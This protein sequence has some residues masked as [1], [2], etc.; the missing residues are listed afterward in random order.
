MQS[1]K[2]FIKGK[3]S[4]IDVQ[5]FS[6]NLLDNVVELHHDL[7]NKTYQHGPYHEFRINDP[8]PRNIHKP[9]VRDRLLHHAIYRQL[10]PIF[11]PTFITDS[12]SC[13]K[14]K[15]T[16]KA[17]NRFRGFGWQVNKND[18][19]TCWVLQCDIR[20]FFASI[21]QATLLAICVRKIT[22]PDTLWLLQE[23]VSSFNTT[24]PGIGLPLGNLTSQL[25]VNIYLNEFDQFA[26]HILKAKRYIRYADDFVFLSDDKSE[27]ES[28]LP[29]VKSFLSG[30]LNLALHPNKVH[31]RTLASGVDFLG[32]VH[33]PDHRVLRTK[34]KRRLKS[35]LADNPSPETIASYLG[36]L[37]H[38]NTYGLIQSIG[39]LRPTSTSG[40]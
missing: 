21:D 32:W 34:T 29:T 18:T 1:W 40:E 16:H 24:K 23:I 36:L 33:F 28:W 4:R 26:K 25:L 12:Y 13:R 3:R 20:Q 30:R 11:D 37:K 2:E 14:D 10:Y 6:E 9:T 17:L 8:K 38:G 7:I 19:R 5:I 15:G 27:L 22:N 35:A 31:I 39:R